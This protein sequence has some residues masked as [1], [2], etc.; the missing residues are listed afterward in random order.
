MTTTPA[1]LYPVIPLPAGADSG[2]DWTTHKDCLHRIV[3]GGPKG[4]VARDERS[5]ESEELRVSVAATQFVDGTIDDGTVLE[6]PCIYID[7]G[8]RAS[9]HL[10]STQARGLIPA[11]HRGCR[12]DRPVGG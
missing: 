12:P 11:A 8:T 1:T 9:L 7:K 2:D 5:V 4:S 10:T 6:P 3:W